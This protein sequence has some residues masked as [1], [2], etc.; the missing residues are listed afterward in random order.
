M[1]QHEPQVF[2]ESA[3]AS[4]TEIFLLE[5]M[6]PELFSRAGKVSIL[7]VFLILTI[8]TV[9]GWMYVEIDFSSDYFITDEDTQIYKY[10]QAKEKYFS[11]AG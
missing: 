4:H 11:D 2:E 9:Q 6:A 5:R 8:L 1:P 7:F 10:T 3:V